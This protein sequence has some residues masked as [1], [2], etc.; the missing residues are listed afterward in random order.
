[1]D[2]GSVGIKDM[3]GEY[4][5]SKKGMIDL[6]E[7]KEGLCKYMAET[8]ANEL[9]LSPEARVATREKTCNH[10]LQAACQRL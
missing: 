4:R 3:V 7:Y 6:L 10:S 2:P 9:S 1:M 5:K 8:L